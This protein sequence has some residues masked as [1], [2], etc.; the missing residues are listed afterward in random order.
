MRETVSHDK[1]KKRAFASHD[2]AKERVMNV[3]G[4]PPP[5]PS[6]QQIS[7]NRTK[8]GVSVLIKLKRD[9]KGHKMDQKGLKYM[10]NGLL[11]QKYLFLVYFLNEISGTPL[12]LNRN[13]FAKQN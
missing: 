1:P 9:Q 2:I 7:P 3:L 8:N 12:P 4:P 13:W 11:D 10:K 6:N 5:T